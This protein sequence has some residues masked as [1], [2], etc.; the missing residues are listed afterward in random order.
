MCISKYYLIIDC[1][2]IYVKK[3]FQIMN[4]DEEI[5]FVI[6]KYTYSN[7]QIIVESHNIIS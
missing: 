6:F 4:V 3:I 7:I 5:F 2:K 1:N